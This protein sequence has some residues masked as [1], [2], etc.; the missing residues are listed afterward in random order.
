MDFPFLPILQFFNSQSLAIVPYVSIDVLCF[1]DET[2]TDLA[3]DLQTLNLVK[4]KV[5][6]VTS[7]QHVHLP[8]VST[9]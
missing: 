2:F 4:I 7:L 8:T 1:V 6:M 3:A 5:H 9:Q